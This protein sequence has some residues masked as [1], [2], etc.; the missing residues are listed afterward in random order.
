MAVIGSAPAHNHE[1]I[2]VLFRAFRKDVIVIAI[3]CCASLAM[4][5]TQVRGL[6]IYGGTDETHPPIVVLPALPAYAGSY[7][8]YG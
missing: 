3:L 6:H 5:A 4:Y 8:S 7:S 2:E 1:R